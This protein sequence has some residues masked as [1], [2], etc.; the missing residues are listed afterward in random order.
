MSRSCD[1]C[2][3]GPVKRASRSHSNIQTK[4]WKYLNLQTKKI[5][6][7]RK[8]VCAKCLKNI[9]KASA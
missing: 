4:K 9:S 6:G 1:V 3:R 8:K 5:D 2:G 7:S